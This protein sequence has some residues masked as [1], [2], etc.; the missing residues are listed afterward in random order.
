MSVKVNAAD[1]NTSEKNVHEV[2][3]EQLTVTPGLYAKDLELWPSYEKSPKLCK[4]F[5][6]NRSFK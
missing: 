3:R 1:E 6:P 2:L 4:Y 5:L